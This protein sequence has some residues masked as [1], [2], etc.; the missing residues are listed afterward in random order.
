MLVPAVFALLMV[1]AYGAVMY[2]MSQ[3]RVAEGEWVSMTFSGSCLS[4]AKPIIESRMSEMGLGTPTLTLV[5]GVLKGEAQLPG[6]REN[7]EK[8][9]PKMLAQQGV[10]Q[11]RYKGEVLL[12]NADIKSIQYGEDESGYLE[13]LLDFDRE[14]RGEIQTL[15]EKE[16]DEQTEIWLDDRLVIYR[17]NT[18]RMSDGFRFVSEETNPAKKSLE[19]ANFLI[20]L[21]HPV[22]PC[23]LELD[24]V[25]ILENKQ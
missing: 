9:I 1:V 10:W 13:V 18:V 6:F 20:L 12:S 21:S 25:V 11:M 8:D 14:K 5:D 23:T 17:P 7:E 22:I 4:E 24:S 15:F 19:A 16:P 2:M 3:G